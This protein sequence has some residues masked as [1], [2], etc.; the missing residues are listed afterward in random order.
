MNR[1]EIKTFVMNGTEEYTVFYYDEN[2]ETQVISV[3]ED[4]FEIHFPKNVL[5]VYKKTPTNEFTDYF[6]K[7][8]KGEQVPSDEFVA[9]CWINAQIESEKAFVVP[10]N[11]EHIWKRTNIRHEKLK[12]FIG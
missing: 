12:W 9:E 3:A 1:E 4:S 5:E 7:N 6:I 2:F 11:F 8:W 10:K